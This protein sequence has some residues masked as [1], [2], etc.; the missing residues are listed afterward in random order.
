M[1]RP[2]KYAQNRIVQHG[3]GTQL[4]MRAAVVLYH[5]G[6]AQRRSLDDAMIADLREAEEAAEDL[7]KEIRHVVRYAIPVK[8]TKRARRK[9]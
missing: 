4:V 5:L 1:K 8:G 6:V 2:L 3:I 9:T 7:W